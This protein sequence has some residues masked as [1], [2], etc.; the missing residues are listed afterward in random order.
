MSDIEKLHQKL[1]TM[2]LNELLSVCAV[3]IENKID[4]SRTDI[5]LMILETRLQKRRML[6]RLGIEDDVQK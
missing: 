3:A 2:P 4:E 5:L 1:M 6:K